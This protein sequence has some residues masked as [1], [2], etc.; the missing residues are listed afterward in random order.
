MIEEEL[1]KEA[2]TKL[3]KVNVSMDPAIV[4]EDFRSITPTEQKRSFL[5]RK[6]DT[7]QKSQTSTAKKNYKYYVDNFNKEQRENEE[8]QPFNSRNSV[9]ISKS[10]SNMT[11]GKNT[12]RMDEVVDEKES[13]LPLSNRSNHR[14]FESRRLGLNRSSLKEKYA[15]HSD[16]DNISRKGGDGG[17]SNTKSA[18]NLTRQSST[19]KINRPKFEMIKESNEDDNAT[20]RTPNTRLVQ[21]KSATP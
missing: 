14:K 20:P 11:S 8:I 6:N 5:K 18:R 3:T 15:D 9:H 12:R 17:A 2:K 16:G 19:I 1:A 21:H 7:A 4:N 10:H 13:Q